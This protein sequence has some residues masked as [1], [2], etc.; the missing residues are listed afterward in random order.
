MS[1]IVFSVFLYAL[2][3]NFPILV[4]FY[5]I[6][7]L[8]SCTIYKIMIY[9]SYISRYLMNYLNHLK[10]LEITSPIPISCQPN[11]KC[12]IIFELLE[13]TSDHL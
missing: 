8:Y 11:H 1:K 3:I 13:I 10:S 2:K 12:H 5:V 9:I 7:I 4:L 6:Y